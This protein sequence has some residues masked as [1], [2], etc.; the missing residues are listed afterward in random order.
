[1]RDEEFRTHSFQ[2]CD[3]TSTGP[4]SGSRDKDGRRQTDMTSE[5]THPR[6]LRRYVSI[7]DSSS[8]YRRER[9]PGTVGADILYTHPYRVDMRHVASQQAMATHMF[10]F[11]AIRDPF[12]LLSKNGHCHTGSAIFPLGESRTRRCA[13]G[14]VRA[15]VPHAFFAIANGTIKECCD[16]AHP[17]RSARIV[18]TLDIAAHSTHSTRFI[19]LQKH[20]IF[21]FTLSI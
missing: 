1:M 13:I 2:R 21:L 14:W 18:S 16:A 10:E 8:L 7:L 15:R 12:Y 17:L 5:I 19:A 11:H 9:V 20:T 6:R 3:T 4:K